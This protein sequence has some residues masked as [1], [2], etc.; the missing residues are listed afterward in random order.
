VERFW[1][2]E[3]EPRLAS[4]KSMNPSW[5]EKPAP[6]EGSRWRENWPVK[7]A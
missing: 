4:F 2:E 6:D 7:R 3:I 5:Y 1:V